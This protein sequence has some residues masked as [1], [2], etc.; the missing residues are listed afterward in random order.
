[1]TCHFA[2]SSALVKRYRKEVGSDRLSKLLKS[3]DLIVISRLTIIE[4]S[5][6]IV[7]RSRGAGA[8]Q[9]DLKIAL[10]LLDADTEGLFDIIEFDEPVPT[11]AVAA[12]R[13]HG[14]K[15][16][17]SIQ[18]AAAL[19]TRRRTPNLQITFVSCDKELNAAAV[20]EGLA[21]ENPE[22]QE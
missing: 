12:T 19:L 5:A 11:L 10:S 7:R 16:G 18:L 8:P 1:M 2:D 9:E 6:A 15:G 14:L 4:V 20:A 17:D 3:A 13:K 22:L 21:V